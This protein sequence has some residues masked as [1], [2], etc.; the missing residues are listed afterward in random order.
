MDPRLQQEFS[1]HNVCDAERLM[2]KHQATA[3]AR[4]VNVGERRERKSVAR[5]HPESALDSPLVS[6]RA[7]PMKARGHLTLHACAK[8]EA[9]IGWSGRYSTT[10]SDRLCKSRWRDFRVMTATPFWTQ[11]FKTTSCGL[12]KEVLCSLSCDT[13]SRLDRPVD[14]APM[15]QTSASASCNTTPQ[16]NFQWEWDVNESLEGNQMTFV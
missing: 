1:Q 8:D 3:G 13:V 4:Y 15:L 7:L 14:D 9:N 10:S 16:Y 2:K 5:L 12:A 6:C 11:H